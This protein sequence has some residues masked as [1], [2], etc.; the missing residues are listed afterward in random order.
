MSEKKLSRYTWTYNTYWYVYDLAKQE[1][2]T[3]F[4]RR[5]DAKK[6]AAYMNEN[7]EL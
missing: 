4:H 2:V 1:A 7:P 6:L 5:R 3:Y